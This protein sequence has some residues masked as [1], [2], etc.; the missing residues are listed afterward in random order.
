MAYA[1]CGAIASIMDKIAPRYLAEEWDNVGL[2]IG[3]GSK[4]VSKIM[5]CLD[6]PYWV[7]DEALDEKVDMIITH[8]PLIFNGIK[9]INADSSL[10]RKIIKLIKNEIAVY[11]SHTNFDMAE[12]GLNDIFARQLGFDNFSVIHPHVED[13]LYKF[14]V[15]VPE[16][17][18]KEILESFADV[19][20]GFIGKYSSCS[21]RGK[22]IGT[23]RPEMG[24]APYIGKLNELQEV[25]EYKMETI[26]PGNLIKKLVKEVKKVHPYEEVAYD[27]YELKNEG[28][29]LGIGR[30]GE[31]K[32]RTTLKSYSEYVKNI[33]NLNTIRF[34]GKPESVIKKVALINGSGGRYIK[35]AMF[36]G[37]DV[38]VTG[39]LSYHQIL[40]A[41]EDGI[42]I[43]DAGH[44]DTEKIMIKAVANYLKLALDENGYDIE[45][46]E[47]KSNIN[48]IMNL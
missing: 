14:I 25:N 24:S 20:A 45:L 36:A 33:L 35:Q 39:D 26:V 15:Y 16:G 29:S 30:L 40:D 9:N 11:S 47:S 18:E 48:P 7:L 8:H 6:L 44:F 22:G 32:H 4:T 34:A 28:I 3:D 12:N 46:I 13:K 37:A 41:L 2:L 31:L 38:V 19:G 5:I 27:I 1:K 17:K 10:G 42:N 43:I 21:F 23:F